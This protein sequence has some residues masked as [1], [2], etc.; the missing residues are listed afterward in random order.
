MPSDTN[1]AELTERCRE[2]MVAAKEKPGRYGG[3]YV[4]R[5]YD[6]KNKVTVF[7]IL[8]DD[9][10]DTY[11]KET[12]TL[13]DGSKMPKEFDVMAQATPKRVYP[14]G[15]ART[16]LLPDGTVDFPSERK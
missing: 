13:L 9:D 15:F 12:V 7:A 4:G 10:P 3:L 8:A 1:W 16:Y 6:K 11:H 5:Y 14:I 2:A